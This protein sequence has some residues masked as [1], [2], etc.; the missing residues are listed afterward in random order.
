MHRSGPRRGTVVSKIHQIE[1]EIGRFW[2]GSDSDPAVAYQVDLASFDG[3]G[4]C[5]CDDFI[6]RGKRKQAKAGERRSKVECK[7]IAAARR[8]F[9]M[10]FFRTLKAASE[11]QEK[12]GGK[13]AHLPPP[14]LK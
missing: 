9:V 13:Y 4:E 7:H 11:K 2:V 14:P 8:I 5:E 1:G 10:N 3:A 12:Q 6:K